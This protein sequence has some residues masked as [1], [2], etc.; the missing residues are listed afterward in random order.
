MSFNIAGYDTLSYPH[1][2]H[3][4]FVKGCAQCLERTRAAQRRLTESRQRAREYERS[5][6]CGTYTAEGFCYA[7]GRT[8]PAHNE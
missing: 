1:S 7:C 8:P 5:R 4:R 3:R 2:Q 6:H